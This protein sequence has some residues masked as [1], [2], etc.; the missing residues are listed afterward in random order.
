MKLLITIL[1]TIFISC[2]FSQD[3][4]VEKETLIKWNL[5][6]KWV[7][8]IQKPNSEEE[9]FLIN[10]TDCM[11]IQDNVHRSLTVK[12]IETF[13]KLMDSNLNEDIEIG[14]KKHFTFEDYECVLRH[15]EY[16]KLVIDIEHPNLENFI[17]RISEKDLMYISKILG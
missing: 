9:V 5:N 3:N 15:N 12:D 8:K 14:D 7:E 6:T 1:S 16:K 11:N 2:C 4:I 13:V 10:F 17:F